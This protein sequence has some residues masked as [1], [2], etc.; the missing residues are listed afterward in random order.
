[1]IRQ[2][3]LTYKKKT[4]TLE[5]LQQLCRSVTYDA[6]KDAVQDLESDGVLVPVK[7]SGT[8]HGGLARKYSIHKGRLFASVAKIVRREA[9]SLSI[10]SSLDVSW[11]YDHPIDE[12]NRDKGRIVALSRFL[13]AE[14]ASPASLQQRSY[15]IFH[16]EKYLLNDGGLLT[17]LGLTRDDL[18]IVDEVDPLMLACHP[19]PSPVHLHLVVENK[20]PWAS[21]FSQLEQTR[22]TTLIL[23]YGWKILANMDQLPRQCGYP[24]D[25]HVIWYFGDFDWEGLLIWHE[26]RQQSA[27]DIR[28][29]VPFYRVFLTKEPSIG[30]TNQDTMPAAL[31]AFLSHFAAPEAAHF[32]QILA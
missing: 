21:L 30:K 9:V 10:P 27:L 22:L 23:G 32:R 17:R 19:L 13:S 6:F 11:Y 20:A 14:G 15:D 18:A 1:M 3:L 2:W 16:D 26:L 29:A 4:V 5:I 31:E 12:W 8:D 25:R 24:D 28:L 7:A